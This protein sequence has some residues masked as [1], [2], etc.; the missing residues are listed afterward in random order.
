MDEIKLYSLHPVINIIFRIDR[1]THHNYD[2]PSG[3]ETF[4]TNN[5]YD[6]TERFFFAIPRIATFFFFFIYSIF[7]RGEK[8][9]L[10]YIYHITRAWNHAP[11]LSRHPSFLRVFDVRKTRP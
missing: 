7:A 3:I 2:L 10:G 9:E 4:I 5:H 11:S 8:K 1:F 6:K